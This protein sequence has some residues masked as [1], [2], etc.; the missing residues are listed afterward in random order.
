MWS[1]RQLRHWGQQRSWADRTVL[2]LFRAIAVLVL[3]GAAGAV[4]ADRLTAAK[5]LPA[6]LDDMASL[7][8]G[9][10]AAGALVVLV[11][12]AE[13]IELLL[14]VPARV[15]LFLLVVAAGVIAIV[16]LPA[17]GGPLEPSCA[18]LRLHLC[19]LLPIL[20]I[21]LAIMLV[22][23]DRFANVLGSR[24]HLLR[25]D[26]N[27]L[28]PSQKTNLCA[29]SEAIQ[30]PSLD[31]PGQVVQ[32]VGRWGEGKSFLLLHLPAFL[33]KLASEPGYCGAAPSATAAHDA[34]FVTA[35]VWKHETEP[36]LHLALFEELLSHPYYL[37]RFGWLRYPVLLLFGRYV[38][39]TVMKFSLSRKDIGA[40]EVPLRLP[41]LGWQRSLE[42]LVYHQRRNGRR[43][44]IVL[45]EIDRATAVMAQAALTLIR[46]SLDLA[47]VT[48]VVS[49]V[50]ELI[51]YKA[52]NPMCATLPD[53]G[54]TMEAILYDEYERSTGGKAL[55]ELS[56]PPN[57]IGRTFL[58][59]D[60]WTRRKVQDRFA[61]KYIGTRIVDMGVPRAEDVASLT[62]LDTLVPY[63][64]RILGRL[65]DARDDAAV[66]A[67]LENWHD[68]TEPSGVNPL[69]V[70]PIRVL[71]SGMRETLRLL[72]V[73][74]TPVTPQHWA[75]IVIAG[76]DLVQFQTSRSRG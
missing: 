67:G 25:M 15:A 33:S 73:P 31:L 48:V 35:D 64:K 29:L 46:R 45:D 8:P 19:V 75:A 21:V 53:L 58:A 24:Q 16:A 18:S 59:Y 61:E 1:R 63:S 4:V 39:D 47:G 36:D 44:V 34:A 13:W 28:L 27:Q 41:R 69:E 10:L 51:R 20:L 2:G 68:H 74:V 12:F 26:L 56:D 38:R 43:T 37:L 40:V 70:P 52:F 62:S 50:D 72:P 7:P 14:P 49:Y 65:P 32:L 5:A 17:A 55:S 23:L 9:V 3:I 11:L 42:R 66:A 71:E 54:S 22:L 60:Q 57:S 30:A 6:A 76:Y